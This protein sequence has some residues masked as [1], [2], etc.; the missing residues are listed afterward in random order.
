MYRWY[1]NATVC[2][3]YL[4]DV[5]SHDR[6]EEFA[7]SRWFTRGWTLQ[8]LIAP[9]SVRFY[10]RTW[11][12]I[13]TKSTMCQNLCEITG[14]E[15][16]ILTGGDLE[17]VS[18][19]R[20]MSWASRRKTSRVED[21][22]YCLLG[23]FDVNIP[24]IY[25]EGLNAFQRLQ[26]AIMLK[27]HDQSLFAWGRLVDSPSGVITDGQ[28]WGVEPLRWK[29]PEE[30]KPLIGL[31]AD[32]IELFQSSSEIKPVHRFSH[33]LRREHPPSL[34]SG[35]V[36]LGLVLLQDL[37]NSAMHLDR[38]AITIPVHF[39]IAVLL[40]QIGE[41]EEK[42]VGLALQHWG[43]GYSG[44][45][46][47]LIVLDLVVRT[48]LFRSMAR[49]RHVL[50]E[51][52]LRLQSRDIVFRR[53]LTAFEAQGLYRFE[54][55]SGRPGW[56]RLFWGKCAI[57]RLADELAGQQPVGYFYRVDENSEVS[58]SFQRFGEYRPG[59]VGHLY[60]KVI[61]TRISHQSSAV[62]SRGGEGGHESPGAVE[63][64]D[65]SSS[66]VDTQSHLMQTPWD[67]WALQVRGYPH[68]FIRVERKELD[69]GRSG[70][71]DV[72]DFFMYPEGPE[73]DRARRA[74]QV[75]HE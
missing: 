42:L 2:Y 57:L 7:S 66:I 6:T 36:L 11:E 25:G 64:S 1:Q 29:S 69:G 74:I 43:E 55:P 3:V 54:A 35:G 60:V 45:T 27:T 16:Y 40:C 41:S 33:E 28:V 47:D 72:V 51:R 61:F 56:R 52:P 23:I 24:L 30:R 58:V 32:S 38:P 9:M 14:I 71:V 19:A 18:V 17:S 13:G 34:I 63:S 4:S 50:R 37:V 65:D 31:F 21:I 75:T 46:D 10:T 49:Q 70:A 62:A 15:T 68:I 20:R 67:S 22:A 59:L 39:K 26:E 44:R 73:A 12:F 5:A 48:Q 8:E 53:H